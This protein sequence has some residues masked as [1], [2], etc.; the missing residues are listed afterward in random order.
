[1]GKV[2]IYDN[3]K[4]NYMASGISTKA[5]RR[6]VLAF[7][8]IRLRNVRLRKGLT[9]RELAERSGMPGTHIS[10][11]ENGHRLP[12]LETLER[13]TGALQVPLSDLFYEPGVSNRRFTA[14][15]HEAVTKIIAKAKEKG[16]SQESVLLGLKAVLPRLTEVDCALI[17][18]IARKM[19]ETK[20]RRTKPRRDRA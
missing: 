20:C 2:R 19:A 15:L 9:Q 10:R 8:G 1:L 4:F 16:T 14:A 18:S 12:S 3:I 17:L 11:I 13:L 6:R 7:L 5:G